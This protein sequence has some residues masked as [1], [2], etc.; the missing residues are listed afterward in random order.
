MR[1][2]AGAEN[3]D[4]RPYLFDIRVVVHMSDIR[5][6]CI[7]AINLRRQLEIDSSYTS[8]VYPY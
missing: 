1:C 4:K 3:R 7:S 6:L 5:H 8:L 2:I